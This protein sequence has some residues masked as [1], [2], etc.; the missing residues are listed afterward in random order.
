MPDFHFP[1][2]VGTMCLRRNKWHQS[3]NPKA[4]VAQ[5]QLFDLSKVFP[6]VVNDYRNP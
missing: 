6:T 3:L 5:I 2:P 4:V 1:F